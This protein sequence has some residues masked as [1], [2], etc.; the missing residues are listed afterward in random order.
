MI[1]GWLPATLTVAGLLALAGLILLP[2]PPRA[3]RLLVALLTVLGCGLL[4]VVLNLFVTRIWQPFPDPIPVTI[5]LWSSIA[6][7]GIGLAIT[8]LPHARWKGWVASTL[9]GLLVVAGATTQINRYYGEFPTLG[10]A[11]QLTGPHR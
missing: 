5:L 11:L 2:L 1:T 9:A 6:L 8:H 7:S 3:R 4:V 10:A